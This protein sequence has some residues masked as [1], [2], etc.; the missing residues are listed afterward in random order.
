MVTK[1]VNQILDELAVN[2]VMLLSNEEFDA[3]SSSSEIIS[4]TDTIVSGKIRILKYLQFYFVQEFTAKDEIAIRKM[5]SKDAAA[6][7][8]N[9]RMIIYE[10]MWDG[11]GCKVNYYD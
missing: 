6:N 8:V 1:L 2:K 11:C 4:E 10:K 9:E 3:L 7:F 5:T